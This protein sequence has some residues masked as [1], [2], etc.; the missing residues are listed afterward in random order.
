MTLAALASVAGT[1]ISMMGAQEARDKQ[2]RALMQGLEEDAAIQDRANDRTSEFVQ[3]TFDPTTRAANYEAE[4]A[5]TEKSFGELLAKQATEG[6]GEIND[7][8]AGAL[9]DT[10]TREKAKSTAA[11][12]DRTRN[13]SR[14]LARGGATGGLFDN[15]AMKGADYSSDMMGF[16]VDSRMNKGLTD[17]RFGA[18]GNAGG[19][20]ALLGGLLSG[21]AGAMG[22]MK[23]PAP[24][25]LGFG[26]GFKAPGG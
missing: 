18:A 17:A 10:Y 3:D 14:L 13:L 7:S 1:G 2:Q 21:G 25:S 16:G 20:M 5:K 9:S 8:T 22:G 15:E 11:A 19:G 23:K 4:A 12:A 6:Q 24:N 26:L